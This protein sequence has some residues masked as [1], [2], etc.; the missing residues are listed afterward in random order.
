MALSL[1]RSEIAGVLGH[2]ATALGSR[3]VRKVRNLDKRGAMY[4]TAGISLAALAC[5][6]RWALFPFLGAGKLDEPKETKGE[7]VHRLLRPDGT[8]LHVEFYGPTDAPTL[9]L[10]HGWAQDRG[11]WYYLTRDL[12]QRF[13][14]IVWDLPGT[15]KSS[16]PSNQDYSIE[17]M[18]RDLEAVVALAE[19]PVVLVGHSLGGMAMQTFC[20][21]FP[22]QLGQR[23]T[24]MVLM[25]TTYTNPLETARWGM[26]WRRLQTPVF[27]PFWYTAIALSPLFRVVNWLSYLN[28]SYHVTKRLVGFGGRQTWR[29]VD[30][31]CRLSA[32]SSPKAAARMSL[33]AVKF[34]EQ[35]TLSTISVPVLVLAGE[36]DRI[37]RFDVNQ[38]LQEQIP[39]AR[40]VT[41]A[42]AGHYALLERHAAVSRAVAKFVE[43]LQGGS[44]QSGPSGQSSEVSGLKRG[45]G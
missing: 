3:L 9:V 24:G 11:G 38:R 34:D 43:S 8:E 22:Q 39:S 14:L 20:R 6:G 28:G 21:L 32:R 17:K 7:S 37:M 42:H 1:R 30:F 18:A 45:R 35:D 40:L 2:A 25:D 15:G 44:S 13:R 10:T 4:V 12:G 31:A 41:L 23:V 29:Q 16:P 5:A 19:Q 26:L 27:I 33:A 36:N